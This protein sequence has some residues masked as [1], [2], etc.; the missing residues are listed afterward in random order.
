MLMGNAFHSM[1]RTASILILVQEI[2]VVVYHFKAVNSTHS[3]IYFSDY[4]FLNRVPL[5]LYPFLNQEEISAR[6]SI[7]P[8]AGSVALYE[9]RRSYLKQANNQRE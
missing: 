6:G 8:F 4:F 5:P 2:F 9:H 7:T 1:R 3:T